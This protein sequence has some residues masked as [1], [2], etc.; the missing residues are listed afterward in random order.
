VAWLLGVAAVAVGGWLWLVAGA[1]EPGGLA[2]PRNGT[3]PAPQPTL[4]DIGR[5]PAA[6]VVFDP[7]VPGRAHSGGQVSD[8]GGRTW[9]ALVDRDGRRI[10]PLGASRALPPV[11]GPA[12]SVL[13]G[14]V[15]F[16][17][18]PRPLGLGTL[19]HGA[20]WRDGGWRA[21]SSVDLSD[22]LAAEEPRWL[23]A[24]VAYVRERPVLAASDGRLLGSNGLHAPVRVRALLAASDGAIWL[25]SDE[26]GRFPLYVDPQGSGGWQPVPGGEPAVALAEGG[27]GV[28]ALGKR[29]GVRS[30]DGVW[31]WLALPNLRLD[32]LAAHPRRALAAVWGPGGLVVS[33][34]A[35]ARPAPIPTG[36][37]DVA[38]AAWDPARDAALILLDRTGDARRLTLPARP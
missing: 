2:E 22:P 7:R 17:E 19:A 3:S 33:G 20:E 4:E 23:V 26:P 16:D 1:P 38:W 18:P 32:G 34:A 5:F 15:L 28:W 8:D 29:L 24:A 12:G 31:Q 35:G 9:R 10:L 37:R 25:A 30:R 6:H 14:E 27:T 13:Y 11:L 21:L 36:A